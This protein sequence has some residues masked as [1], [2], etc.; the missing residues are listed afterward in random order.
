MSIADQFWQ[1]AKEALLSASS[2]KTEKDRQAWLE[3]ART[4][5]QAALV[6]GRSLD[7]HDKAVSAAPSL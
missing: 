2:A 7:D 5:T 4:F 6:E 3:L 1:Y